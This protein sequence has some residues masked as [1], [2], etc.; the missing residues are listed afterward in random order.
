MPALLGQKEPNFNLP[1]LK[2]AIATKASVLC[3][4]VCVCVCVG[5][6]VML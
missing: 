1:L 2:V 5:G 3:V 4:C 6:G